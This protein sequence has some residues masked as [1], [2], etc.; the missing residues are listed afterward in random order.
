MCMAI[1]E[2]EIKFC[3]CIPEKENYEGR[4]FQYPSLPRGLMRRWLPG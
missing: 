4:F 2:N 1:P 3:L